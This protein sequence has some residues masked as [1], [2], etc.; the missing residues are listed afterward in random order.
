METVDAWNEVPHSQRK[1]TRYVA[2]WKVMLMFDSASG[3]PAY[4][5]LTHDLSMTGIS[6]QYPAEE[7]VNSVLTLLLGL[8]PMDTIPRKLI[9]LKAQVTSARPFRGSYR[10]GMRFIQN[11]ELDMWRQ[12]IDSYVASDGSLC[13]DPEAEGLPTLNF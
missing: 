4:K 2:R 5:T 11:A 10:L 13:P 8:P 1:D 6:V 7:K 3:K 9:K 12:C